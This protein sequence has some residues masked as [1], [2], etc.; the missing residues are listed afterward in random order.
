MIVDAVERHLGPLMS[1]GSFTDE[2]QRLAAEE[3]V[4]LAGRS[5]TMIDRE[6]LEDPSKLTWKY[7]PDMVSEFV[8]EAVL[9]ALPHAE[10][11]K[12]RERMLAISADVP[13]VSTGGF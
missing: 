11:L 4:K 6:V 10:T 9:I 12:A 8:R 2:M 5:L 13:P 7:T 1:S 3:A